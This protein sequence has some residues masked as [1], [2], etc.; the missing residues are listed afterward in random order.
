MRRGEGFGEIALLHRVSRTATVTAS[1]P[2]TLL[3][4][5]RDAF[6]GALNAST[7]VREAADGV[8]SRLVAEAP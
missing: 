6:L 3:S 4:V 7:V 1:E 8:A 5:D 2:T